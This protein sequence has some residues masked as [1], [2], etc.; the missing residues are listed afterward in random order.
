VVGARGRIEPPIPA[1]LAF[2]ERHPLPG[3]YIDS[4]LLCTHES[5]EGAGFCAHFSKFPMLRGRENESE[6]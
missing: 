3:Q 5:V 4:T 2:G 1:E 6:D